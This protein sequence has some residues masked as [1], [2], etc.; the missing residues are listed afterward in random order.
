MAINAITMFELPY[1]RGKNVTLVHDA[2]DLTRWKEALG[3]K[4]SSIRVHGTTKIVAFTEV[5]WQGVGSDIE[6]SKDNL[7]EQ[8][9][10]LDTGIASFYFKPS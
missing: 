2:N 10:G 1:F 8:R 5:D 4:V 9:E 7:A 3:G 6:G